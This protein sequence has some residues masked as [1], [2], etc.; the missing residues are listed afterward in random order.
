MSNYKSQMGRSFNYLL[1]LVLLLPG[2]KSLEVELQQVQTVVH[3][4][5]KQ[6]VPDKRHGLFDIKATA[7]GSRITLTGEVLSSDV[8]QTLLDSLRKAFPKLNFEDS[9]AVLPEGELSRTGF[10]IVKISVANQR[11]EPRYQAELVNQAFLGTI[12][13]VFKTEGSFYFVQNQ[14]KYLGWMSKGSLTLVDSAGVATWQNADRMICIANYDVV[15]HIDGSGKE[16]LVDLVPGATLKRL[17]RHAGFIKVETPDK[18]IGYVKK[19]SL[20]EEEA[21]KAVQAT[22]DRI[23]Q[24]SKRFLGAPYLWGGTSPKGFDCSGFVQTVFKLNNLSLPRDASQQANEGVAVEPGEDFENLQPGDLVCFGKRPER[25]SHI[26][27]YLGDQLYIHSSFSV[28][29]N[30]FDKE[31]PLYND[32]RY[33]RFQKVRRLLNQAGD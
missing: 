26:G 19:E 33:K 9:I 16:V 21:L 32:Y 12:V 28:H 14:D 2:C 6:L 24:T 20:I 1:I 17:G 7:Q 13:R 31:H 30:S 27:I 10:G 29:V 11:R 3:R 25:I 4:V 23:I 18:R 8:S 5:G 15:V 22:R